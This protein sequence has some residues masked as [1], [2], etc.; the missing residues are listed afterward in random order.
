MISTSITGATDYNEFRVVPRYVL[1]NDALF[2]KVI[3]EKYAGDIDLINSY[4]RSS[5]GKSDKIV[6]PTAEDVAANEPVVALWKKFEPT[7]DV[8][9]RTVA[10]RDNGTHPGKA[11]TQ[12]RNH[13]RERFHDDIRA[14]NK[15]FT[16]EN[17]NFERVSM[18]Q[19]RP[20]RRSWAPDMSAKMVDFVRWKRSLHSDMRPVY[21]I[22]SLFGKYLKEEAGYGGILREVCEV[23]GPAKGFGD[24][25][26]PDSLSEIG[27]QQP[28]RLHDWEIF[29]REKL[30]FRYIAVKTSARDGYIQFLEKK[31]HSIAKYNT[32]Y[33]RN[34]SRFD[35]I[36]L[37]SAIPSEGALN[38]DWGEF[39]KQVPLDKI[40]L[41][42]PDSKFRTFVK[43]NA[44]TAKYVVPVHIP[45]Y[46]TDAQTVISNSS[47][48]RRFYF[49]RNYS[50]VLGYILLH[51]R[52]LVVTVIYCALVVLITL[53]VNPLCAYA[54]SR[55]SLSYAHSVMLFMLATMAFPAEVAMIPNFLLLKQLGL[56]NTF[57]AL[58]LPGAANGFSIFL[59]KGF[60]DSLPK[61]LYEA[62]ILDGASESR[63]FLNLTIPLSRPIF[64]VI[65]LQAFTGAYGAFMFALV[66]CQNPRMW[67]LMVWLYELQSD[68]PIYVMMAGLA[69]AAIPTLIIFIFAQ[70]IIM[71]GI[72]LPQE[73]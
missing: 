9:F 71:R 59:L 12:Y 3:D 26:L 38:V 10:Y 57:W 44:A 4:Y 48:I 37:P 58:V 25:V 46:Y 14:M 72:I 63:M 33:S 61:E 32:A 15:E 39:L 55:Y 28:K 29:V 20:N 5:F 73:K 16:E 42:T 11:V 50:I 66:V 22:D 2:A 53:I 68:H 24:F 1:D 56:L 64:A 17:E 6:L 70:N 51:G 34:L 47:S 36:S 69:V 31:Y 19:E 65:A 27:S 67:T 21:S 49:G 18:P 35:E 40:T 54:L 13:L 30:P 60:F 8:R 43:R 23:W 52:S 41:N 62:G 7:V 45:S